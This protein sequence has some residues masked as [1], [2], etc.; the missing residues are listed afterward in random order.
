MIRVPD[1]LHATLKATAVKRGTTVTALLLDP[2]RDDRAED[3]PAVPAPSP[4]RP[5]PGKVVAAI[6]DAKDGKISRSKTVLVDRT[7][8]KVTTVKAKPAPR[9][10]KVGVDALTGEAIYR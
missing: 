9:G 3:A 8:G 4:R 2:W 5:S 6:Q 7:R 10:R 1:E